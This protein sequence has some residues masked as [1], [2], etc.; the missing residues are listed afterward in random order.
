MKKYEI[1][2]KT[3][4]MKPLV[5]GQLRALTEILKTIKI[6]KPSPAAII[7]ALGEKLPQALAI[8]LIEDGLTIKEAIE[9]YQER[10]LELE[11][12]ISPEETLQVVEDFFELTP[13]SSLVEKLT[14]SIKKI[15]EQIPKASKKSS[16]SSPTETSASES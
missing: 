9:K 4:V 8:V 16:T 13:V 5:L 12:E 15:A 2:G 3:Y 10:A 14:G 6:E 11:C 1:N 7:G